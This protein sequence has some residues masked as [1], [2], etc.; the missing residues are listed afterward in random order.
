MCICRRG[1]LGTELEIA[2][3][4]WIAVLSTEFAEQRAWKTPELPPVH[5][6]VDAR[7]Q[8]ARC[9]AVLYI[10]GAWHYTD[11]APSTQHMHRFQQRADK[12][13]TSLEILAI[14]VG[15]STFEVELEGRKVVLW[16]D[17]SGAEVRVLNSC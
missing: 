11:G 9:A 7:G 4:W 8:P 1:E 16:S 15:L 3:R 12:Q 14:A 6:F 13:I 5:L 2:L 10:D 17:N